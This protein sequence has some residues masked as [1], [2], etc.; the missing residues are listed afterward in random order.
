MHHDLCRPAL[1]RQS[2]Y[3]LRTTAL[4]GV[5]GREPMLVLVYRVEEFMQGLPLRVRAVIL[6]DTVAHPL[7]V[8]FTTMQV[9]VCLL[10]GKSSALF[11]SAH[12]IQLAAFPQ[13][14]Q[15]VLRNRHCKWQSAR[16]PQ[17]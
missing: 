7:D 6:A 14:L 11:P 3:R 2:E 4:A 10:Q 16:R 1:L 13:G 12:A 15:S 17:R 5:L 9:H 8:Q